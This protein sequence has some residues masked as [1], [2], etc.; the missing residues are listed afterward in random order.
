MDHKVHVVE[1]NPVALAAAL[2]GVGQCAELLLEAMLDLIGDGDGLA[3]VRGGGHE[4]EIREAGV[5]GVEFEDAGV[6][7][8]LV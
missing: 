2:H 7:A 4:E 8:L 6:F 5:D 3:V 1:Q